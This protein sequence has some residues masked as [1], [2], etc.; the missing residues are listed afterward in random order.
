MLPFRSGR[1]GFSGAS[2]AFLLLALLSCTALAGEKIAKPEV[3]AKSKPKARPKPEEGVTNIPIATG[4]DA[5]GLVLPDYDLK[6]HLRGKLEAGVTKRLD[7]ERIEF[8]GVKFTTFTPETETPDLEII[9]STSVFNLKT[10]VLNSSERTTVK[11]S[12]FEITGDKMQFEM[13]TR[14]GTLAGN[15]KMVVHG[16]SR[17]PGNE[18]E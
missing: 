8:R 13:L 12:D 2:S 15:V 9:M 16:K 11:R 4:H 17:V 18:G 6:G 7:D 1:A 3:Q 14:K 10:Q 5:K